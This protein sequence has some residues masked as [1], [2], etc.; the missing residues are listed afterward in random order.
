MP[1]Q[2]GN[3]FGRRRRPTII[4]APRAHDAI[5][6]AAVAETIS[7]TMHSAPAR[8]LEPAEEFGEVRR[9]T[10]YQK[11]MWD[12]TLKRMGR[13]WPEMTNGALYNR[14]F[15]ASERS[16]EFNVLCSNVAVGMAHVAPHPFTGE[17]WVRQIFLYIRDAEVR[18]KRTR[19]ASAKQ[20]Y[21]Q[22]ETWA[23]GFRAVRY[24][25]E[26]C[27][28]VDPAELVEALNGEFYDTVVRDLRKLPPL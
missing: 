28:D 27:S 7:D 10:R 3:Q 20:I 22:L 12:W 9:L 16:N 18:A 1:F 6:A 2:P 23:R 24:E 19:V 8:L 25:L 26:G 17:L 21:Q 15:T 11:E 5:V 13:T 14:L 4:N